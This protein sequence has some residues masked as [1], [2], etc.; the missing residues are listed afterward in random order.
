MP[1]TKIILHRLLQT[2]LW[3]GKPYTFTRYARNEYGELTEEIS[4]Q[5][6]LQGLYHNG[7]SEHVTVITTDSG[8]VIS[9]NTPYVI[10]AWDNA[11]KLRLDDT[12]VI[13]GK[14]FKVTGKT[15]IGEFNSVGEISLEVVLDNAT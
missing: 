7:S 13:N 12:V 14:T 15:N 9:K 4:E 2:I 10:T 6:T 8:S 5:I 1:Y 3:Q 11:K